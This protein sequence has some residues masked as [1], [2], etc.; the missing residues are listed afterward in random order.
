MKTLK[1]IVTL[2]ILI[3]AGCEYTPS[4]PVTTKQ[5][6]YDL[7]CV[8]LSTVY[9][10]QN[11]EAGTVAVWFTSDSVYLQIRELPANTN[12]IHFK[13]SNTQL[14][15]NLPPGQFPFHLIPEVRTYSFPNTL[16][17]CNIY[18]YI[19]FDTNNGTGWAGENKRQGSGQWYRWINLK[20]CN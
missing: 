4:N 13:F 5:T 11:Q 1:A 19:H 6:E 8:N 9:I 3:L 20:C 7:P 15:G 10:N 17:S 18:F 2:V 16:H 12:L 14:T